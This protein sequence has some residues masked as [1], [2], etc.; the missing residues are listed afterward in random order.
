MNQYYWNTN[1]L[2]G[3]NPAAFDPGSI[4]G[5]WINGQSFGSPMPGGL[6][7]MLQQTPTQGGDDW[8]F[9]IQGLDL[10]SLLGGALGLGQMLMGWNQWGDMMDIYNQQLDMAKEKWALTKEEMDHIKELRGK[11]TNA[12]GGTLTSG[13]YYTGETNG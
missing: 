2:F 12:Y 3:T 6:A 1:G 7:Q 4:T 5:S 13:N 8:L 11:L 9:G 10:N